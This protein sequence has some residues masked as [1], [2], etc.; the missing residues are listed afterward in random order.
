[1]QV[2]FDLSS[3]TNEKLTT[4]GIAGQRACEIL[5]ERGKAKQASVIA[6]ALTDA[7]GAEIDRRTAGGG[8][9]AVITVDLPIQDCCP[10]EMRQAA[11]ELERVVGILGSQR[12]P[13][14][15][16]LLLAFGGEAAASS[17]N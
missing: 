9:Q 5:I 4:T 13:F 17:L 2:Q 10:E 6:A 1:M 16:T 12:N 8:D 11:T 14:F 3:M 15:E 7:L